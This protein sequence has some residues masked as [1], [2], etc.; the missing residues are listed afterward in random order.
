ML[1][2][3]SKQ[4][5]ND[6]NPCQN[7]P[8]REMYA[9]VLSDITFSKG[10]L[11]VHL[12]VGTIILASSLIMAANFPPDGNMIG[13]IISFIYCGFMFGIVIN[14]LLIEGPTNR[15]LL[16]VI[17]LC[18][19]KDRACEMSNRFHQTVQFLNERAGSDNV[20]RTH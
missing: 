5:E 10:S 3:R 8:Y 9:K 2:K 14:T 4:P 6:T 13:L 19:L 11:T 15:L 16:E 20:H 12:I 7:E 17:Y 1:W 18:D